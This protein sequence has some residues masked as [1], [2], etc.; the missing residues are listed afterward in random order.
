[1]KRFKDRYVIAQL[2]QIARAGK[3]GRAGTDHGNLLAL[4]LRS[5][6]RNK[7]M[8]SG[9]VGNK[10]LQLADGNRLALDSAH[11]LSLALALLRADTAADCRKRGGFRDRIGRRKIILLLYLADKGGDIDLYRTSGDT[12][13]VFAV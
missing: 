13:G 2:R 5:R 10:T 7:S 11:T 4:L 12:A 8:L 3:A 6:L 9:P 1:M